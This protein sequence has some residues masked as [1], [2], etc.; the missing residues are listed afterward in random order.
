M[1]L[2]IKIGRRVPRRWVSRTAKKIGGL[3]TFQEN[4]WQMIKMG[5]NTAEKK[6]KHAAEN[7]TKWQGF[8]FVVTNDKEEEDLNYML[9]WIKITIQ[10]SESQEQEEY[11]DYQDMYKQLG[12]WMKKDY[13][14]DEELKKHFKTKILTSDKV[15]EA[16]EKGYGAMSDNNIANKLLEMGVLTHIEWV[17]DFDSRPTPF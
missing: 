15:K 7:D 4:L 13:P 12:V 10:G 2:Y 1:T 8:K 14:A 11:N 3:L 16:Y 9:E 17:K 5:I 6:A